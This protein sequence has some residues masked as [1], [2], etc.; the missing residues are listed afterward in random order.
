MNPSIYITFLRHGRS[1]ADDEGVMEGRYDSPLT[2]VGRAQALARAVEWKGK[3]ITYDLIIAS[4]LQRAHE[5]ARIIGEILDNPIETDPDWMEFNN[6]P[7]AGLP[8]DEGNQRYP[9][10][11]FRNPFDAFWETGES[12]WEFYSRA[13]RALQHVIQKGEGHYLVVGHGGILCAALRIVVGAQP[14]VN[15]QGLWFEFGDLGYLKSVYYLAK[16]QW[17][18]Q[19]FYP[20]LKS[21]E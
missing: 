16:H 20:G 17:V 9:V 19:S 3:N 11:N 5:T 12:E 7:L 2:E 18:I 13:A 10:P 6:G 8:Y 14:P 1:R 21:N 15:R 4:T